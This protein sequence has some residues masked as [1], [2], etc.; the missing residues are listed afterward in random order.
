MHVL[1]FVNCVTAACRARRNN[2]RYDDP[3]GR[4]TALLLADYLVALGHSVEIFSP[5]YAKMRDGAWSE[6]PAAGVRVWHAPTF[7]L[8]RW[9]PLR[10]KQAAAHFR[11]RVRQHAGRKDVL[12]LG[13]NYH[14][15]YAAAMLCAHACGLKTVIVYRDGIFLDPEW[16]TPRGLAHERAVYAA[17]DACL[18]ANTGL[19]DRVQAVSGR[20]IPSLLQPA[21]VDLRLLAQHRNDPAPGC[22]RILYTGNFGHEQ[23]FAQLCQWIEHLPPELELDITGRGEKDEVVVLQKLLVNHSNARYHGFLADTAFEKIFSS[24]D[25]CLLLHNP[26]SPYF[27]TQFP[28]KF[29]DYLSRNKRIVTAPDTRLDSFRHLPHLIVVED[30]PRGLASLPALLRRTPPPTAAGVLALAEELRQQLGD[31]L[32]RI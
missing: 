8:G 28:S 14:D 2:A 10:Q 19:S 26:D 22:Q 31:F 9:A 21:L 23:G 17:V 32:G 30:F 3:A 16:Q 18:V 27:H 7:A 6:E 1:F 4:K 13:L 24:A 25:A 5:S 29:Y 20:T 12:V 11:R 15:E